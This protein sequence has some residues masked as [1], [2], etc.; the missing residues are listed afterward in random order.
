MEEKNIK[1]KR[2]F[3]GIRILINIVLLLA[4]VIVILQNSKAITI[5]FLWIQVDISLAL[6]IFLT[7]SVGSVITLFF[8]LMKK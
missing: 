4:T 5:D 8:L 2:P 3:R 6:L 7:G 1:T